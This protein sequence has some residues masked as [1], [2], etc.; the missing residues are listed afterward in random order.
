MCA[1]PLLRGLEVGPVAVYPS[2]GGKG[3][4][5]ALLD[6][7]TTRSM[8]LTKM[9]LLNYQYLDKMNN[10]IGILCYEGKGAPSGCGA[11]PGWSGPK[12]A[13]PSSGRV[14]PKFPEPSRD[15]LVGP[16]P[17]LTFAVPSPL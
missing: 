9:D 17:G 5:A 12:L 13:A 4:K 14:R 2:R 10:N 1:G 3:R 15:W 11:G 7:L 8:L 6:D 16:G